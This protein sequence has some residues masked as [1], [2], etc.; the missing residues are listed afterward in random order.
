MRQIISFNN[1][2]NSYIKKSH[3]NFS[4]VRLNKFVNHDA[5][6][7]LIEN[8]QVTN[9]PS[10]HQTLLLKDLDQYKIY[11][12]N[13]FKSIY[14]NVCKMLKQKAPQRYKQLK[15]EIKNEALA[16]FVS[17]SS[18]ELK[19]IYKNYVETKNIKI[20][21][22]LELFD[23]NQEFSQVSGAMFNP[24]SGKILIPEDNLEKHTLD[25]INEQ[26]KVSS[27][28]DKEFLTFYKCFQNAILAHELQHFKQLS[29]I[30][31][32]YGSDEILKLLALKGLNYD[33]DTIYGYCAE[34][35]EIDEDHMMRT[36]FI[37]EDSPDTFFTPRKE[38]LIQ[39]FIDWVTSIE[40]SD[41][42]LNIE[43]PSEARYLTFNYTETLEKL[44]RIP[45]SQILHIHGDVNNPIFGHGESIKEYWNDHELYSTQTAKQKIIAGMNELRKDV[46]GIISAN[47]TYFNSLADI[48]EII[49]RGISYGPIDFPYFLKL[50]N[51]VR[52]DCLWKL[53]WH[54]DADKSAAADFAKKLDIDAKLFH[55]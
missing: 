24:V 17:P 44:Y 55:F 19:E 25:S 10:K 35:I 21:P 2:N 41:R 27:L 30:V 8:K 51:S 42:P 14:E 7:R 48:Q 29:L 13:D 52:P 50:K 32:V 5:T 54:E 49:V 37:I 20:H 47:S 22:E 46:Q 16:Y 36:H 38:E 9:T 26:N 31:K 40:I 23:K 3:E 39:C 1:L 18:V 34:D 4:K 53:S 28:S 43:V 12:W 6:F 45:Q 15:E 11:D 33:L